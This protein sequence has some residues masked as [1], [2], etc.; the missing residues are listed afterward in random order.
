MREGARGVKTREI[1][2]GTE[3]Q[4]ITRSI[5]EALPDWFG[6]PGGLHP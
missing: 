6:V 4:Q 5:L 3:K 2:E 1:V